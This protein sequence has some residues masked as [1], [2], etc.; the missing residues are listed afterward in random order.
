V[1]PRRRLLRQRIIVFV[2]VTLMVALGITLVRDCQGPARGLGEQSRTPYTLSQGGDRV[3]G[4]P[5]RPDRAEDA[6]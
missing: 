2:V 3:P 4:A 5:E 1:G 6:G